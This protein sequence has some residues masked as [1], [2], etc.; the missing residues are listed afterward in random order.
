MLTAML[1]SHV[2]DEAA[3]VTWPRCDIDVESCWRQCYRVMLAMVLQLNIVLVVVCL[4]S[5]RAESIDVLSH[6]EEVGYLCW[7]VAE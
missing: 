2:G 5:S 3:E 6:H 1:L 7:L 4:H